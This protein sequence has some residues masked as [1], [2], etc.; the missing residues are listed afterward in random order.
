MAK[1]KLTDEV[2]TFVVTSLAMF[3]TPSTVA[4]AVKKD[5][6]VEITR[7]AVE[8][9]DPTKKAGAKLAEK[10]KSLFDEARKAFIEDTATIAISHKAV[11][12]RALQ[13]MAEKAEDMRNLPLAAQLLEQAAK[14]VGGAFTNRREHTGKDGAP[15]PASPTIIFEGMPGAQTDAGGS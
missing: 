12:L 5:Y 9:Y 6:G 1:G 3:D 7:Q 11:R 14:E 2:Q 15:L 4:D 8:C 10:W 13:R